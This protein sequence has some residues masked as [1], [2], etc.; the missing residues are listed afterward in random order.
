[1][2]ELLTQASALTEELKRQWAKALRE[3]VDNAEVARRGRRA[4]TVGFDGIGWEWETPPLGKDSI[5]GKQADNPV[6]WLLCGVAEHGS[7]KLR[8]AGCGG[9]LVSVDWRWPWVNFPLLTRPLF[10][11]GLSPAVGAHVLLDVAFDAFAPAGAEGRGVLFT[12]DNYFAHLRH[13]TPLTPLR[14][15][16]RPLQTA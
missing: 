2:T 9:A 13:G 14:T 1:M 7:A 6:R 8:I 16:W 10:D 11:L 3:R 12:M 5:R 15:P 4:D